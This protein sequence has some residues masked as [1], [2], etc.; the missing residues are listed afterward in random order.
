MTKFINQLIRVNHAGEFGAK[1]IY[2]GQMQYLKC[3]KDLKIVTTMYKQE[4]RH[5]NFFNNELIKRDIRPTLLMPLWDKLA[6]MLGSVTAK[7]GSKAAMA[8]TIAIEEVIEAHYQLQINKLKKMP[9][10]K[11]LLNQIKKIQREEIEH[12]DIAINNNIF[13]SHSYSILIMCIKKATKY[14]IW[15]SKKI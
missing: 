13:N 9:K 14:A 6:F 2:E 15:L 3:H 11:K 10:E 5:L 12:K 7:V 1:R 4:L 8:C